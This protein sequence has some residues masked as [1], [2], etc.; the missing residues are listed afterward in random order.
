MSLQLLKVPADEKISRREYHTEKMPF[1]IGREFDCDL[2]LSDYSR[3]LSRYHVKLMR[4]DAGDYK[5]VDISKNGTSLNG[6]PM[7]PGSI[8]ELLDGDVLALGAYQILLSTATTASKDAESL[9]SSVSFN[10]PV[11]EKLRSEN[12]LKGHNF[13]IFATDSTADAAEPNPISL[14]N[15]Y[16][17]HLLYDPFSEEANPRPTTVDPLVL[18]S[19]FEVKAPATRHSKKENIFVI[20]DAQDDRN[21]NSNYNV[22]D[23]NLATSQRDD[24][25]E[26]LSVAFE[27]FLQKVD[28]A[29]L[30][31]EMNDYLGPFSR[32][33]GRHWKVYKKMFLRKKNTGEYLQ[34]FRGILAEELRK[35]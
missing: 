22:K 17:S 32:L 24:L 5:I 30:E 11:N 34:I 15:N 18:G 35:K 20:D 19:N 12:F 8:Y 33:T 21:D 2:V 13:P 1:I 3:R 29:S 16:D 31:H 10:T 28:P 25:W 6:N 26:S 7:R 27:K 4:N 9:S 14:Q 23:A